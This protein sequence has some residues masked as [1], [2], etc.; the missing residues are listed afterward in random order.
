LSE[1]RQR[2]CNVVA[3]AK[4]H[5]KD[6]TP[7]I[8]LLIAEPLPTPQKVEELQYCFEYIIDCAANKSAQLPSRVKMPCETIWSTEVYNGE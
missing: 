3:S 2:L 7:Y 5:K 6:D 4:Q 8:N 1:L